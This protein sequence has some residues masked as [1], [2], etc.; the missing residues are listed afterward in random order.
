MTEILEAVAELPEDFRMALVEAGGGKVGTSLDKVI[1]SCYRYD[2]VTRRY[3]PFVFGFMRI[4]AGLT[5]FALA[6]L[7]T[8]LWRKE[9]AMRKRQVAVAASSGSAAATSGRMI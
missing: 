3:G 8:V 9:F 2:P 6:G 4:G 7:L 5:F 1:L